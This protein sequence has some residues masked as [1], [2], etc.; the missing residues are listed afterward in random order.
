[1]FFKTALLGSLLAAGHATAF[2][3]TQVN[4]LFQPGDHVEEVLRRDAELMASLTRRQDA[5]A[6]DTAPLASLTPATGDASNADS[7]KWEE[8]TK[9]ACM[10]TLGNL[11][12]QASNPSGIAVCYNLP[13]LD[14]KTGVF[15]A[16]LRMYNV[17][18]PINPWVGV[19][20]ADVSM[21]LSYLGA[22]VQNMNGN[23]TKRDLSWPPVRAREMNDGLLVERQNI[24]S[25]TEMKVLM[26]VGRV[27]SNLMGSAM[28]QASLQPLLI[29]QIDLAARNPVTNQDVETTLSSQEASFVNGIFSKAGSA[30]TNADP[31]AAASASAAV[32]SAAPFVIPGTTFGIFPIGLIVTSIWAVLFS[33]AVGLGTFGRIKFRDQYRRRV[34]AE[35]ARGVRTI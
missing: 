29:P 25:M 31:Q 4:A 2:K 13:F 18:A 34:R 12:G 1:M 14:T 16:E 6:V 33:L 35:S 28:T 20:A 22:T 10:S 26:Y 32:S 19:T 21:T 27:N 5:N 15:Q 3:R 11:N 7:A 23:F 17:S 30:P 24:N 9:Q 8:Q